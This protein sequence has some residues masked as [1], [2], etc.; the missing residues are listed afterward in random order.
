ML[1]LL[2]CEVRPGLPSAQLRLGLLLI[3]ALAEGAATRELLLTCDV[4]P[5]GHASMPLWRLSAGKPAEAALAGGQPLLA[6]PLVVVVDFLSQN[7]R[8]DR[9]DAELYAQVARPAHR[10][11]PGAPRERRCPCA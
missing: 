2:A 9:F 7:M 6:A 8:R 1:S 4:A 10:V 3:E 5:A 11:S